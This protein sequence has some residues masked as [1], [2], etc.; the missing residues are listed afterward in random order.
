MRLSGP[1]LLALAWL[2]KPVGARRHQDAP[3]PR[4]MRWLEARGLVL[5]VGGV[6]RPTRYGWAVLE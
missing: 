3:N 4:T 6:M 5:R 2:S 1:Q